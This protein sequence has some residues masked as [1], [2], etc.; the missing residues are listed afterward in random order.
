MVGCHGEGHWWPGIIELFDM[1][2]LGMSYSII[3]LMFYD[4]CSLELVEWGKRGEFGNL[5]KSLN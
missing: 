5:R 3:Q 2:V 1:C 4:I